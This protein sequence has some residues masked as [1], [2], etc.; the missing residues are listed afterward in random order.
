[1][2]PLI[3][4]TLLLAVFG[5]CS[6]TSPFRARQTVPAPIV[7]DAAL[8][9]MVANQP[10][11]QPTKAPVLRQG[12][13]SLNPMAK[14]AFAPAPA[15]TQ[16]L[17]TPKSAA[18]KTGLPKIEAPIRATPIV[19][20]SSPALEKP[21][22]A[23]PPTE[24]PEATERRE[25]FVKAFSTTLSDEDKKLIRK[26]GFKIGFT[27]LDVQAAMGEPDQR[28]KTATTSAIYETWV[29]GSRILYFR[30]GIL[31]ASHASNE[32]GAGTQKTP[33]PVARE[34]TP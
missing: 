5:G 24:A 11:S 27:T 15:A 23:K 7:D 29:Y 10:R 6:S 21:A 25:Q 17:V 32:K 19:A 14:P 9:A 4:M 8:G 31:T 22:S 1:M 2:K 30:N 26:G 34:K 28:K 13:P 18:Q 33:A 3:G 12:Q 20:T 16:K